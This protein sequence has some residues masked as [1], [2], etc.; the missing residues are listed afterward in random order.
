MV[1]MDISR[2]LW[3]QHREIIYRFGVDIGLPTR[4]LL[5]APSI[6][7]PYVVGRCRPE[8]GGLLAM[9]QWPDRT[10]S[11]NGMFFMGKKN[12]KMGKSWKIHYQ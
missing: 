11:I 6:V 4:K 5:G 8:A 12:L 9:K 3:K 2:K 1:I 10:C 7:S